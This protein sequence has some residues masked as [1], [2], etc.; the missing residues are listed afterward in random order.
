MDDVSPLIFSSAI[1]PGS[2]YIL[3]NLAK[4]IPHINQ[5]PHYNDVIDFITKENP[6][7]KL[8]EGQ[9]LLG[10]YLHVKYMKMLAQGTGGDSTKSGQALVGNTLNNSIRTITKAVM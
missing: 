9:S 8:T 1:I 3:A 2:C 6:V 7:G 5:L 10:E 4:N